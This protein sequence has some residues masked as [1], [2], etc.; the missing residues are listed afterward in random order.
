MN[1]VLTIT[2]TKQEKNELILIPIEEWPEE[3]WH[4]LSD[5]MRMLADSDALTFVY[6]LDLD[7]EFVQLRLPKQTWPSLKTAY[8]QGWEV[9]VQGPPLVKLGQFHQE[10][11]YLLSNIPGNGNYGSDMVETVEKVFQVS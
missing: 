8:E 5:G 4:K 11:E 6:V 2:E 10:M 1:H 9:L 3:E 7:G